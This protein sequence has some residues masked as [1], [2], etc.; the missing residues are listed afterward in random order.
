MK[1]EITCYETNNLD[2]LKFIRW[3]K[4]YLHIYKSNKKMLLPDI[5]KQIWKMIQEDVFNVNNSEL[6]FYELI[7]DI[8]YD[9]FTD[10]MYALCYV[11]VRDEED[12]KDGIRLIGKPIYKFMNIIE[13]MLPNE[14]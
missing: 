14:D 1:R 8:G 9:D 2:T 10:V 12:Y 13:E 6:H 5:A 7:N 3:C 4:N 11:V